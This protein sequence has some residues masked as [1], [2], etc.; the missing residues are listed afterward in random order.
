MLGSGRSMAPSRSGPRGEP[1]PPPPPPP[2]QSVLDPHVRTINMSRGPPD[3][4]H[5]FGICVKG[6]TRDT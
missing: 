4:G 6:G 1:P 2:P 5:G 3:S